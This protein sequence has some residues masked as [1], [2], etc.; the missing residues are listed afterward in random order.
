MLCPHVPA[1]AF[2]GYG[3]D[4]PADVQQSVTCADRP[5]GLGSVNTVRN[6]HVKGST[7]AAKFEVYEDKSGQFRFRLKAGNGEVVATG[8]AYSSR[9]AA[10]DGCEAVRRAAAAAEVV[11]A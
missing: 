3:H 11:D 8:E 6:Y 1:T 10:H 4:P 2:D 9:S 5:G 7:M